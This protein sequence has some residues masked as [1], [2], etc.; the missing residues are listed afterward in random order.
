M[1]KQRCWLQRELHLPAKDTPGANPATVS[2]AAQAESDMIDLLANSVPLDNVGPQQGSFPWALEQMQAGK[3]V[4]FHR[5]ERDIFL[6][7]MHPT[8]RLEYSEGFDPTPPQQ[9]V[10]KFAT[11]SA[12]WQKLWARLSDD[13][14]CMRIPYVD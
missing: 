2:G 1:S 7:R 9:R 8:G 6:Y 13:D 12:E 4:I 5:A 10:W 3:V 11:K 14:L